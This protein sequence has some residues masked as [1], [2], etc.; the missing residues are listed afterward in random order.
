MAHNIETMFSVRQTPWHGLGKVVQD[1]PNAADAIKL[2]GLDWTVNR[3]QAYI[4]VNGVDQ[5]IPNQKAIV[6]SSDNTVLSV[7]HDNYQPLQ[8][9]DAFNFFN[10]FVDSGLASFETAGALRQGKVIW[11][12]A[13]L[14]RAPIEVGKGGDVVN[15]HLLL[16]NSHDGSMAVRVGFTPIRVVCNNTLTAAHHSGDSKLLRIKHAGNLQQNM[17]NVQEI[18]NA[19]DARF[20]A[21][22]EQYNKLANVMINSADLQNYVDVIF[23]LKPQ[24]TEREQLRAKKMRETITA[25]FENGAGAH[26]QS[27]RGTLWGAYNAVTEY[28]THEQGKELDTR[29]NSNWFGENMRTNDFALETA[30]QAI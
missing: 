6:R 30:L 12:L 9:V 17:K 13:T 7:M 10:P 27:A 24:G 11:V 20:E 16:S 25:L 23:D 1:A 2:A 19:L 8:N 14:N 28:L 21:T 26:L 3:Q 22:A 5:V 18:V 29:L 4:K 15:K